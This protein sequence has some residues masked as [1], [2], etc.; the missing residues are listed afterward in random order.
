MD[1]MTQATTEG[2]AIDVSAISAS[3]EAIIVS[4]ERPAS[5]AAIADAVQN[6][7][8]IE[9]AVGDIERAILA[10]NDSYDEAGRAFRIEP[11]AGG[12]RLMT[13]ATHAPVLVAFGK[14]RQAQRLSRAALETLAIVAYRQPI[15]RANLEAIRGVACGE[16]LRALLERQLVKIKGRAEELGRPML[17]GTTKEFLD[18]FGL[19]SLRDLPPV[20]ELLP[21]A[22]EPEADAEAD[23][24]APAATA[25]DDPTPAGDDAQA[26]TREGDSDASATA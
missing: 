16:V 18:A 17:Y 4:A 23:A 3:V 5:S 19:A 10:L 6:A 1:E 12:W 9:A 20:G 2:P 22:D 15:T 13:L 8:G 11:V 14:Q 7:L 21:P 26:D 24:S 25:P